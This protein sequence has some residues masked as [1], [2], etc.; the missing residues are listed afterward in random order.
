[1]GTNDDIKDSDRGSNDSVGSGSSFEEL[2]LDQ[3]EQEQVE[4][5]E[6]EDTKEDVPKEEDEGREAAELRAEKKE[7]LR[8][9]EE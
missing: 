8:D 9:G 3:E 6:K 1:M 4:V 7:P 5:E 2:D